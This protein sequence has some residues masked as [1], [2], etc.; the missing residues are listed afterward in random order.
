MTL[1]FLISFVIGCVINTLRNTV[2]KPAKVCVADIKRD[3]STRPKI[4]KKQ[5]GVSF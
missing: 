2:A 1:N 3:V 4:S 5:Y